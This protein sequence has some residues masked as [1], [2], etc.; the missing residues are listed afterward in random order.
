MT[1]TLKDKD[2]SQI[3]PINYVYPTAIKN[4]DLP[5]A[6]VSL[7]INDYHLP[8]KYANYPDVEIELST[9]N[10][11]LFVWLE[12]GNV[13]GRFSENGFHMFE[14][15][16]RIIFHSREMITPEILKENIKV[17]TVSDIYNENR[18][19][20]ANDVIRNEKTSL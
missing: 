4:V 8:G 13:R 11:A 20:N 12:A 10:I 1:L 16:R 17:T 5:V 6:N 7:K 2:G 19:V 15:P 14:S 9:E 3:A 18:E